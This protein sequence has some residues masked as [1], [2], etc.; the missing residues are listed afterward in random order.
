MLLKVLG[1]DRV[2]TLQILPKAPTPQPR[3]QPFNHNSSNHALLQ[4][5]QGHAMQGDQKMMQ[6]PGALEPTFANPNPQ[7]Q[8]QQLLNGL[9]LGG[10]Q[11]AFLVK[12]PALHLL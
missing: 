3:Q 2:I 9:Q 8:Q 6:R 11:V 5:L 4:L 7:M 12:Y 10:H 1:K